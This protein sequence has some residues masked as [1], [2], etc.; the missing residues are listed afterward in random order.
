[1]MEKD[2]KNKAKHKKFISTSEQCAE[3]PFAGQNT[4]HRE[5]REIS[6]KGIFPVS[7]FQIFLFFCFMC[8]IYTDSTV[9]NTG[10]SGDINLATTP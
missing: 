4:Q 6:V 7:L 3:H 8:F 1:M 5:K 2:G 10:A 9:L